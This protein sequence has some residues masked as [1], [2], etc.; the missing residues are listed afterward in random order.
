MT[1]DIELRLMDL[2]L[3]VLEEMLQKHR[4]TIDWCI[5]EINALVVRANLRR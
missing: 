3:Q 5:R 4:D 1:G 2:R